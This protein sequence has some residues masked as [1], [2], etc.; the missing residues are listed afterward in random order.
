MEEGHNLVHLRDVILGDV[1]RLRFIIR[2]SN[3]PRIQNESVADHS[4][5]TALYTY[6]IGASLVASGHKFDL[7]RALG[8]ALMHDVDE[9]FSGDFIRMFKHSSPELKDHID[10]ACVKFMVNFVHKVSTS[11][12]LRL[13][14]LGD[15][16]DSKDRD[17]GAVVAFADYLSVLSYIHQEIDLGN[18][19][20]KRQ[21][22][23]LRKFHS[24]FE[25][26]ER[27]VFLSDYIAQA[28]EIL[29]E[30]EFGVERR[31][32]DTASV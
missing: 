26:Q 8:K 24:S 7:G 29:D 4:Y 1:S 31:N 6:F 20:M 13:R 32:H 28:G 21:I 2:F 12:K 5:F 23:E 9:C 22:P 16:L 17:E 30:I 19:R 18:E 3:C 14:I 10:K 25:A 11:E 27:F 15:W